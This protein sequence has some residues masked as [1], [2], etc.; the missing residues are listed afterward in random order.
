MK[1]RALA[2]GFGLLMLV[3]PV[4][5]LIMWFD[6]ADLRLRAGDAVRRATGRELTIAGPLTL[7]WSPLPRLRAEDVHLSNLPGLSRPDMATARSIEAGV[8]LWPLLSGRV[9]LVGVTLVA[10]DVLLEKDAAGLP[11]WRFTRPASP[12][13][14]AAAAP[15]SAPRH[16]LEFDGLAVTDGRLAW[17]ADGRE[18]AALIPSLSIRNEEVSGRVS[19]A[20]QS[21]AVSGQMDAVRMAALGADLTVRGWP[22]SPVVSGVIA[23]LAQLSPLAGV[24]LPPLRDVRVSAEWGE[25][26]L[27]RAEAHAG[28]ADL[29][30]LVP[31][32][33]ID[34]ADVT[35]GDPA[36]PDRPSQLEATGVW[37][38]APLTLSARAS[39]TAGGVSLR[40]LMLNAAAIDLAGDVALDW[41]GRPALRGSI[42]SR[43]VD[44]AALRAAGPVKAPEPA[45]MPAPSAQSTNSA[46]PPARLFSDTPLPLAALTRAD[47]DLQLSVDELVSPV[48]M[49]RGVRG[50]IRLHEGQ[51]RV[52]PLQFQTAGG[53]G[54]AGLEA[55]ASPPRAAL[56][57]QASG[58]AMEKLSALGVAPGATGPLDL[59]IALSGTGETPHALAVTATG[60]AGV[61]VVNGK[62]DNAWLGG[63]ALRGA[64]L[65]LDLR[66]QTTLRCLAVR[67]DVDAGIVTLRAAALDSPRLQITGMGTARLQDE[68]MDVRL[69]ASAQLGGTAVSVPVLVNGNL[70]APRARVDAAGNERGNERGGVTIGAAAA[71]DPCPAALLAARNGRAGPPPA[72]PGPVKQPKPADLFRSLF[73]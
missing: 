23:D 47:I 72:E 59:D 16:P 33:K 28:A 63:D 45:A 14:P 19:V 39:L 7:V 73:R 64:G 38:G 49:V 8:A 26:G 12:T 50:Q 36:D 40:G 46:R 60:H 2:A 58:V 44:W 52:E 27:R 15:G 55:D 66:G 54:M 31:G 35:L 57:L 13:G 25:A 56:V 9:R 68:T 21:V 30:A 67:A 61:A 10:P 71:P 32:L 1:K 29:G 65:P 53:P 69:R 41:R 11:N 4:V 3:V 22:G 6:P 42:V 18:L 24:P 20:G 48:G 43:H 5:G 17:R 51:L 37:N 70:A 62:I 34:K